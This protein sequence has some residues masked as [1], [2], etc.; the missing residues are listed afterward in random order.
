[1][2]QKDLP[3][4]KFILTTHLDNKNILSSEIADLYKLRWQTEVN[5]KHQKKTL[6][7]DVLKGKNPDMVKKIWTY[8]LAYNIILIQMEKSG[9]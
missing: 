4:V 3:K 1:M 8:M 7:M 2:L 9:L 5:L 6:G